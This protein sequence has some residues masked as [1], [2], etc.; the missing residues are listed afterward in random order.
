MKTPA[1]I[2]TRHKWGEAVRFQFKTERCC[3]RCEL[4]RVTRHDDPQGRPWIEWWRDLEQIKSEATPLCDAR[5]QRELADNLE[6]TA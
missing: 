2:S 1:K 6:V 5:L 3:S 4:V